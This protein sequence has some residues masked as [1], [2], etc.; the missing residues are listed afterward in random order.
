MDELNLLIERLW[1]SRERLPVQA[2]YDAFRHR[3]NELNAQ[4]LK[5]LAIPSR[6]QFYR[7]VSQID[8]YDAMVAR[9]GK[10]AADK[11]FRATGAG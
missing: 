2:V 5:P 4:K 8:K 6:A 7:I 9:E 1:L 10:R 3:I 11:H